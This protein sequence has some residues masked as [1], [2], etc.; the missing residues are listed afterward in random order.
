MEIKTRFKDEMID[1]FYK[2][3][4]NFLLRLVCV[5]FC[6]LMI[7]AYFVT[8]I[9]KVESVS[10]KGN[11]Y[12]KNDDIVSIMGVNKKTFLFDVDENSSKEY[13]INHPLVKSASLSLSLFSFDVSIDELSPCVRNDSEIYLK[14]GSLLKQDDYKYF[15]EETLINLPSII[16][17]NDDY[18][19]SDNDTRFILYEMALIFST[20]F[21]V[22]LDFI[23]FKQIE[24]QHFF[25]FFI[26]LNENYDKV[27]NVED[28]YLE[29]RFEASCVADYFKDDGLIEMISK[30][31]NE[32]DSLIDDN[33]LSS[34]SCK[35]ANI[36]GHDYNVK[37]FYVYPEK[38]KD[39]VTI[40]YE[41]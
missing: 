21:N 27:F 7:M 20:K 12:L 38:G 31:V 11:Y 41:K 24:N 19:T 17:N 5:A 32:L 10:I 9:S 23:D 1:K 37:T 40:T 2:R 3:K 13:L 35:D 33:Y 16:Q 34:Y 4:R 14:D 25:T 15:E 30:F 36:K 28:G 39:N 22:E 6:V 18:N 8:P 29:M 26:K